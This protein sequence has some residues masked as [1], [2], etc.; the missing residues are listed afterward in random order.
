MT[1]LVPD[2]NYSSGAFDD[3]TPELEEFLSI[4]NL[5]STGMFG[6]NKK[7]RY[8]EGVLEKDEMCAV[9]GEGQWNETKD[10]NLKLP[11]VKVLVVTTLQQE[12]IYLSDDP[13][14]TEINA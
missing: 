10:H 4:Y 8:R 3:A 2:A 9:L 5:K 7:L 11:S 12:K 14:T 1:Y 13:V 6:F